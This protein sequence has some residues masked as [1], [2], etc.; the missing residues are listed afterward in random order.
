MSTSNAH[1]RQSKSSLRTRRVK[2]NRRRAR[3]RILHVEALEPRRVLAAFSV[4]SIAD[5]VDVNPGDGLAEDAL[6]NTTLRAAVM[7]SNALPGGDTI[8]LPPGTYALGITGSGEDAAAT[9]DLDVTDDLV[10][11]GAGAATTIIDASGLADV[12][13]FGDRVLH[14]QGTI[15]V[16]LSGVTI[17]GGNLDGTPGSTGDGGG[18]DAIEST[19]NITDS[20][21]TANTAVGFAGGLNLVVNATAT[22]DNTVVSNNV[23]GESGGGMV[24]DMSTVTITGSTF[25]GNSAPDFGGAI[26]SD[27]ADI[28]ISNSTITTHSADV[29]G[30][31]FLDEDSTLAVTNCQLFT[32]DARVGG[33]IYSAGTASIS[34]SE[35]FDNEADLGGAIVNDGGTLTISNSQFI[36]NSAEAGGAVYSSEMAILHVSNSTFT[37]NVA[38]LFGEGAAIWS[39]GELTVADSV[40]TDN[41]TD[42]N[43]GA[44]YVETETLATIARSTFSRNS[45]SSAGG[46]VFFNGGDARIEDSVF[47]DN[48]TES[49]GGAVSSESVLTVINSTFSGNAASQGGGIFNFGELT[50]VNS[51]VAANT[52]DEGG[53]VFNYNEAIGNFLNSLVAGNTADTGPDV[54]DDDGGLV[55]SGGNLIGIGDGNSFV[56][57]LGGDQVGAAGS[58]LDPVLGPLQDNGGPTFTHALLAGSPAIDAGNNSGAPPTDQRGAA[59]PDGDAG[60]GSTVDIGAFEAIPD[61]DGIP[62]GIEDGAPNGGDGNN[63]GILDSQQAHVAS[64]PN[65]VDGQ[66]VTLVSNPVHPLSNVT[67]L[68][69]PGA[70]PAGVTFPVGVFGFQVTGLA[71]GAATTVEFLVPPG[72]VFN[73]YY[74]YGPTPASFPTPVWYDFDFDGTLGAEIDT[75]PVILHFVDGELGDDDLSPNGIIVEP[76]GPAFA[77]SVTVTTTADG[78]PGS[79]RD[80]ILCA[81]STPGPDTINLPAGSYALT[82]TGAS[83]DA[84]ATGDLDITDDLTIVGAGAAS[85]IIDAAALSDRVLQVLPSVSLNLS[86]VT[87]TGG[88]VSGDGGGILSSG[89]L[90][91]SAS[92]IANNSAGNDGGGVY[93]TGALTVVDTTFNSNVSSRDGGGIFS[94]FLSTSTVPVNVFGSTFSGNSASRL[95]GGIHNERFSVLTVDDSTFIGNSANSGGA[96]NTERT[97]SAV[98]VDSTLIANT[99][100]TGGGI[101]NHQGVLDVRDTAIANNVTNHNGAGVSNDRG[102]MTIENSTI[103]SNAITGTAS[104]GGIL[105]TEGASLSIVNSTISGNSATFMGGGIASLFTSQLDLT[106]VTITNNTAAVRVGGVANDRGT[107]NFRN[108]IIAANAAPAIPDLGRLLGS[109]PNPT[110][111]TINSLGHN[112]VGNNDGS[113]FTPAAGDLVGTPAAPIDPLLGPLQNN[114]GPTET[115]HPLAGSPVIEAGDNNVGLTTDQRGQPRIFDGDFDSVATIDIGSVEAFSCGLTVTATADGGIGSLRDAVI[116]ANS[117][118]GPNTINVPAGTYALTIVGNGEDATATGDLDITDD[119]TIVGAGAATTIVDATGLGDRVFHVISGVTVDL[120][121]LT[122][123]GGDT[124]FAAN[125]GGVLNEGTLEIND[126]VLTENRTGGSVSDQ[127]HGAAVFSS[128]TLTV[129]D[130]EISNNSI[131][132]F[133]AGG[134]IYNATPGNLMLASSVISDNYA[135]QGGGVYNSGS[136]IAD[137]T[138]ISDNFANF[139]GGGI[140]GVG[141]LTRIE[142]GVVSGNIQANL[143]SGGAG[144]YNAG[145]LEIVRT[146]VTENASPAAGGGLFN[147]SIGPA[148]VIDS[149]FS[150]NTADAGST[151]LGGGAIYNANSK[152]L[153]IINTTLTE[154]SGKN[155]GGIFNEFYGNL[156]I[157]SSTLDDNSA[158][159]GGGIYDRG[160]LTIDDSTL[161]H[162]AAMRE[163][164]G[165]YNWSGDD[166]FTN[167]T[168]SGN[169]A[170]RGGGIWYILSSSVSAVLTSV[171]QLTHVTITDNTATQFPNSGGIHNSSDAEIHLVNSIIA[172]NNGG[173]DLYNQAEVV[174]QGHNLIG[175]GGAFTPGP[176]D[177]IGTSGSPIDPLLG[178]LQNNGGQTDTHEPLIASPAIDAGDNSV[179]LTSD[180]RGFARPVDGN[181]DTIAT[182]DIGAVEALSCQLT[183]THTGDSGNGSLREAINCAN[184]LVG[185]NTIDFNIPGAGPHTIQP[186]SALPT[187]TDPVI[188]DGATQPGFAGS[189]IVELDGSLAGAGADGLHITAGGSTVRGLVIN[190]FA[191]DG[192]RLLTGGGNQIVGNFIGTDL[193]GTAGLGNGNGL[194]VFSSAGNVIGGTTA[195]NRNLISGNKSF[196]IFVNG[197]SASG[198]VIQGSYVGVDVTGTVD[199]GNSVAGVLIAGGAPNNRV[200]GTAVGAG[201][202]ISGNDQRGVE[203][204]GIGTTGNVVQGNLIGTD[205]TGTADLGNSSDGVR[206]T[207]GAENNLVGGTI[208]AARNIISGNDAFGVNVGVQ[209]NLVQGNYIGTDIAGTIALGNLDGGVIVGGTH[210]VIGG[211]GVGAGNLIS[212]NNHDGVELNGATTSGNFVQGNL[213]GTDMTGTI[214]LPNQEHGVHVLRAPNNT[215]GDAVAGAGNLIS[216]NLRSGV[217]LEEAD[218]SGNLVAGNLIGTDISGTAAIG[219]QDHGVFIRKAA[220]N[221]IGG[222]SAAARNIIAGNSDDGVQITDASSTSNFVQGNYVGTDITGATPLGNGGDGVAILQGSSNTIGGSVVG[223]GNVISANAQN[224]VMVNGASADGNVIQGN[225][226]GTDVTGTV[227]LGN[228]NRGVIVSD[229]S[230]NWIGGSS[231]EARN[232]IAG[233]TAHGVEIAGASASGNVVQNNFIGTGV[234]GTTGLGNSQHG[235]FVNG[236]ASNVIGTDGDGVNDSTEGNVISA[237]GLRGV[238][239]TGTTA[240][241]NVVAGNLIGTD[242]TGTAAL[243][244]ANDGVGITLGAQANIIGTNG[245]GV[246]DIAERNVISANGFRGVAIQG[247]GQ[248]DNNVVAGNF[249]GT[250]VTGALGLGNASHGVAISLGASNNRIGTNGDGVADAAE[251]NVIAANGAVGVLITNPGTDQNVVAGNFIGTD[252]TG[253]FALGNTEQGVRIDD[254]AQFNVVGT[255]GASANNIGQRNLISGNLLY[256]VAIF[257]AG[258]DNNIVAGNFIGTDVSGTSPV[259]NQLDGVRVSGDNNFNRV[260]TDGNGLGDAAERNVISGNL[261][262]G[263]VLG[264]ANSVTAGNLIGTNAAGTIPLAN[265]GQ[266]VHVL[267]SASNNRIGGALPSESNVI[268]YNALNG[269]RVDSGATSIRIQQN[270]IHANADLG[271]DLG[272]DGVTLND[273][274]DGDSGANNLQNFP[275]LTSVISVGGNTTI[276]GSLNSTPNTTFT[277]EF[278]S[279]VVADPSGFGEGQAF[280]GSTTVATDPSGNVS[281]T[282]VF[283]VAVPAGEFLSATATDP[284]GNTSEFSGVE[285]VIENQPPEADANG[286]Y[287]HDE[288]EFFQLDA[289]GSSDPDESN[290]SLTFEWDLDYDGFT[291]DVD[292]TGE[293]PTVVFAD[294]FAARTIA[295]RVTDSGGLSDI[296]TTTLEILN[297][298]P[299]ITGGGHNAEECGNVAV[300]EEVTVSVG[301]RDPGFDDPAGGTVEDF[302]TSTI[303][304]GDGA[305]ETVPDIN[306]NE[307]PGSPGIFTTGIVSGS[308]AY[309]S[310]GIFTITVTVVDDDGGLAQFISP[311]FVTS[312]DLDTA[313]GT[314]YIIGTPDADHVSINK[315]G[316]GLLKVH[317]DFL[318]SGN[319]RT[320]DLTAVNKIIA[321]MCEG[322]DHLT[323]AGNIAIPAIIH[324]GGGGDHLN[325]GGGPAVLLGDAGDDML[326]GGGGF[327]ILIGG[328]GRD[329]LVGGAGDDVLIGGRTQHDDNDMALMSALAAWTNNDDYAA[330]VAAIDA[331]F[332]VEDDEEEDILTGSSGQDLFFDGLDDI[333]TDVKMKKDI[334]QVL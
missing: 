305:V 301:F 286:P 299:E 270:S 130:T 321:Y 95:G 110:A 137:E 42:G 139:A 3:R 312:V 41:V 241:G 209:D 250:D 119:L 226:V 141:S 98:V 257:T 16:D 20:I 219:N 246:S 184:F 164:G 252:T 237:N 290:S 280:V 25:S 76:S 77:C 68:A 89:T 118:P 291:F 39:G 172:D 135:E 147:A 24:A 325:A 105:N 14:L 293:Q 176:G 255:D 205:V 63:D 113:F 88:S 100:F 81:N 265:G 73:D 269:V 49:D 33:A 75:N 87:V 122:I 208:A 62:S 30:A 44:I 191:G 138:E 195:A 324:G 142:D 126:S 91:V 199:L 287:V 307:S 332:T 167:T 143:G 260:G 149:T 146:L 194:A 328:I 292:A 47:V 206:I 170:Q 271:I 168:I 294:N 115:H 9:G 230:D 181:G 274:G 175:N 225:L 186:L 21:I 97:V 211:A 221:T 38:N 151:N 61:N 28:T 34:D 245:D 104:G 36:G 215:I 251:R 249:I 214:A 197:V 309:M 131:L 318:P 48:T 94:I 232:V 17:T 112:L 222:V 159:R 300:G 109:A 187:V 213:I 32:N 45:T 160:F 238:S 125:G 158:E 192:I 276:A 188:I 156:T 327:D 7:E 4:N 140:Y 19:L 133:G 281:F 207:S 303:D 264:S 272:N 108:T 57:G 316:N 106:N 123:R 26:W 317:A 74:K 239:I 285:I 329:R 157:E 259:A 71:S 23:S 302:T 331:L 66:Y 155:G 279:N 18:I 308:H 124:V 5:T 72:T 59:R 311:A 220:N 262:S 116:C 82:I 144:I 161:S 277:L 254:R 84:A 212:G 310:G 54:D 165:I 323:I 50:L 240:S 99:A 1:N 64:L 43:A 163:G 201:N 319:F 29:G 27:T 218:A 298:D 103:S 180:Q 169:C 196:G 256:G 288:G 107:L 8:A 6:G 101:R 235:V 236:A 67:A 253:T 129:T 273:P 60:S 296:V 295:V 217:T 185:L 58:P 200:G 173:V 179:A 248:T 182:T 65:S 93:S 282:V 314:L 204:Q 120:S 326:V 177:I 154:N 275:V 69:P 190:R 52:A 231:V 289:S 243:G 121:G 83:E 11:A 306:V 127:Y 242:V 228:A 51:T 166:T 10:I 46:A 247:S 55:S 86:G 203:I 244:N 297:V 261:L 322:D 210:N 174:S 284:A 313:T 198:N 128:G 227:L 96:I 90:N 92:T 117:I 111:G 134:G 233:S 53:G 13:G 2:H 162:N 193:T 202:V 70:P 145:V 234:T 15:T 80:A 189:P 229:G 315:Q 266:G 268:A 178:P 224:G 153:T 79:L 183:V 85:T 334:E 12:T 22:I 283:P 223:A 56:D 102:T 150:R 152:S 35:L 333:L 40:F 267:A 216:G 78:G 136:M 37:A 171:A 330:R 263:V 132:G 148:T 31:I 278:F 258:T 320:F 114:G 304:W